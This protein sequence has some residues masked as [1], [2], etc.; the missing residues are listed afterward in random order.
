M[1]EDVR[2]GG[3]MLLDYMKANCKKFLENAHVSEH[4]LVRDEPEILR[5]VPSKMF[6]HDCAVG[7][8]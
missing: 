6:A 4:N 8:E 1:P 5:K 2:N 7:R 3:E